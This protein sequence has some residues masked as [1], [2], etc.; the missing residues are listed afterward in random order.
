MSE[1][2]DQVATIE[3]IEAQAVETIA[4]EANAQGDEQLLDEDGNPIEGEP[5]DSEDVEY[6]GKV[7]KGPKGLKEAILRQADYTRKTQEV[8][9][10][11]KELVA[12]QAEI[13]QQAEA[14]AATFAERV[15]LAQVAK[16]LDEYNNL[17]WS[18][19]R[20]TYGVDAAM[21]AQATWQ[22]LRQ[23]QQDLS[24]SITAKEAEFV[25]SGEQATANALREADSIL[26]REVQGFGPEAVT[27]VMTVANAF[28]ITPD[29]VRESFLGADGKADVRTFKLLH[30]LAD[31]RAFKAKSEATSTKSV[32]AQKVASVQPVKTVAAGGGGYK[33]GLDDG[34]PA[35]EWNRRRTAQLVKAGR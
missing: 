7:F 28:G 14:K 27:K 32:A 5:D 18:N 12:R 33:P 25:R 22:Q 21:D 3:P 6:E 20:A 4:D 31:L 13:A 17:D 19:Y 1:E 8:A 11:R 35:D 26:R 24:G 15:Q 23:A 34:L 10:T 30:E 16:A 9:E 29:E 2:R